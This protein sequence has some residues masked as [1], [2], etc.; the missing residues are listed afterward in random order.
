MMFSPLPS[1]VSAYLATEHK[2]LFLPG[3]H[4]IHRYFETGSIKPGV[5]GGSK[6]KVAT[7][8]VVTKIEE[9]K[10][11]NPS[12]FAW[13]IRDRLLQDS[14]CDKNSVPSVS[15]I[16]RIVR[17]RAQQRQKVMQE[18]V[19]LAH[20]HIFQPHETGALPI[21]H[22]DFIPSS[23]SMSFMASHYSPLSTQG[24][25]QQQPFLAPL[26]NP[27]HSSRLASQFAHTHLD[28]GGFMAAATTGGCLQPYPHPVI[29]TSSSYASAPP[30]SGL[31]AAAHHL[32]YPVS[33]ANSPP[34]RPYYQPG[35]THLASLSPTGIQQP[36][37]G[38]H[39]CNSNV[40]SP[41]GAGESVY[42]QTEASV[43]IDNS[44]NAPSPNVPL[45]SS[46][47]A[48]MMSRSNSEE[49]LTTTGNGHTNTNGEQV[50][51]MVGHTIFSVS[52]NSICS[53]NGKKV[54]SDVVMPVEIAVLKFVCV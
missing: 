52:K 50:E 37:E 23:S 38:I 46:D 9:Y 48:A 16:N 29:E 51:G 13:E 15:S 7:P 30:K 44:A 31:S 4:N 34:Q 40:S 12:I 47:H 17:T 19:T 1:Q 25:L 24:L 27:H 26:P 18:K 28:A 49:G 43:A 21:I 54:H 33:T 14:V 5:I 35:T 32:S 45:N 2:Y 42:Q 53:H 11:E 36:G 22:G 20:S 10:Q 39:G 3:I 8:K 6:P 41:N